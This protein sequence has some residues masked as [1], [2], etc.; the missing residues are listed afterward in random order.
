MT[1][2]F[3]IYDF[4]P[5]YKPTVSALAGAKIYGELKSNKDVWSAL[6]K[7]LLIKQDFRCAYCMCNLKN[8][9]MNVEHVVPIRQGGTNEPKNLVAACKDCNKEKNSWALSEQRIRKMRKDTT[10]LRRK[11]IKKASIIAQLDNEIFNRIRYITK[12]QL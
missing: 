12:E 5:V 11:S 3:E 4:S 2:K 1:K 6:R 7:S 10:K 9:V 8:Q